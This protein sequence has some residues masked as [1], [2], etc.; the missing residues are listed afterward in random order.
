MKVH[1][2]IYREQLATPIIEEVA[3][4]ERHVRRALWRLIGMRGAFGVGG[5]LLLRMLSG[6]LPLQIARGGGDRGPKCG[7]QQQ[8][9]RAV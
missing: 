7:Q 3:G 1:E 9:A 8:S 4:I 6:N 5:N 2:W